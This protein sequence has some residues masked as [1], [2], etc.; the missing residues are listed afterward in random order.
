MERDRGSADGVGARVPAEGSSIA[1]GE[2]DWT[3][4]LVDELTECATSS[5]PSEDDMVSAVRPV[6]GLFKPP[7][8]KH[9]GRLTDGHPRLSHTMPA[10]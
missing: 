4:T 1:A 6:G 5:W 9:G 8:V 3:E 10:G 2:V 7:V